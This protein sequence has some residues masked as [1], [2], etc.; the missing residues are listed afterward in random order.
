MLSFNLKNF[1]WKLYDKTK[2]LFFIYKSYIFLTKSIF[3]EK[4]Q[5]YVKYNKNVLVLTCCVN[6]SKN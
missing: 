1:L 6:K 4:N 3:I 5:I 2:I